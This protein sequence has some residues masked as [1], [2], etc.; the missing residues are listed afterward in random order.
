MQGVGCRS[1]STQ[2]AAGSRAEQHLKRKWKRLFTAGEGHTEPP[3]QEVLQ[4]LTQINSET[5]VCTA[6]DQEWKE[7]G[8]KTARGRN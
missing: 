7:R 3:T 8:R 4:V 2:R 6:A 1:A 5:P